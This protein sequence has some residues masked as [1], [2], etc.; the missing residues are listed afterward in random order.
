MIWIMLI[1]GLVLLALGG[2]ILVRGAVNVAQKM[3]LSPLIIGIVLVG[4]GTS[5]P[6]L[7]TSVLAV[8]QTPPS[9]GLA[10]GNVIGSNIA[11][12][13][14]VLGLTAAISPV[15][16]DKKALRRDGLF[17]VLSGLLLAIGMITGVLSFYLG[18]IMI[19]TIV[20]Y[21]WYSYKSE[22][23][24]PQPEQTDVY[25]GATWRAVL[26][27]IIGIAMTI[28]GARLLV[29]SAI[30]IAKI[31]HV[32]D[33]II[34]L[35]IVAIGTSLPEIATSVAASIR[36]HNEIAFG[37]IV[38]SN[39]Y[40]TLFILGVVAMLQPIR[41]PGNIELDFVV[42]AGATLM[43]L[44]FGRFG[45][46]SRLAGICMLLCYTGYIIWLL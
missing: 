29:N 2:D 32:S 18:L 1:L 16:V 40:N 38:G 45:R 6:E 17:L 26:V 28:F 43:M 21:V 23:A 31:F 37:N 46:I 8:F 34:G 25:T 12:I 42:M 11:N 19:A 44:L 20:F 15:L 22:I 5:T 27:T 7:L 10:V 13:L 30:D 35:T 14:L 4:F 9:P 41:M 3:K 36:H 33:T 24:L 39:I